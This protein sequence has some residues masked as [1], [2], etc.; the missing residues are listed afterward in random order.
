MVLLPQTD[1][2][3]PVVIKLR[4]DKRDSPLFTWLP[5][6]QVTRSGEKKSCCNNNQASLGSS[7]IQRY[8]S[9][10]SLCLAACCCIHSFFICSNCKKLE[11]KRQF[12]PYICGW[13]DHEPVVFVEIVVLHALIWCNKPVAA[14]SCSKRPLCI[15]LRHECHQISKPQQLKSALF[16]WIKYT[17]FWVKLS[18]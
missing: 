4:I 5:W 14:L 15:K 17:S 10:L 1:F 6:W 13:R 9:D 8:D 2:S 11:S 18:L 7:D 16:K 3:L 12:Y